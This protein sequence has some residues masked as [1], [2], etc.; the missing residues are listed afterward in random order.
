[1]IAT[2]N[3]WSRPIMVYGYDDS[4][5]LGGP[6]FEAQ[7]TCVKARNM[8][9]VRRC[10]CVSCC[11]VR[12]VPAQ[13]ALIRVHVP[14]YVVTSVWRTCAHRYTAQ[15]WR[16]TVSLHRPPLHACAPPTPLPP[17]PPLRGLCWL[18]PV[19]RSPLRGPPFPR[20]PLREPPFPHARAVRR[21]ACTMGVNNLSFLSRKG[22]ITAP[23]T[24]NPAPAVAFNASKTYVSLVV[25]DGDNMQCVC[26]PLLQD[27][28]RPAAHHSLRRCD[29]L[30]PSTSTTPLQ[31]APRPVS[32]LTAACL[33]AARGK[34]GTLSPPGL[35]GSS[36]VWRRARR[37]ARR[38][39]FPSRGP[40]RRTCCSWPRT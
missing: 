6:L 25:G 23:L 33:V 10:T 34:V 13:G 28:G 26:P 37:A 4:F 30:P 9:L 39:A 7:T 24:Q 29:V 17:P 38:R 15:R 20:Y 36:S 2:N 12:V 16:C 19:P 3:P 27:R 21:Q 22:P 35:R 14:V 40:S 5:P 11:V 8:G 18:S 31:R 1:M 32:G